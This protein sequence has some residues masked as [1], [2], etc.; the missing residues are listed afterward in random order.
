VPAAALNRRR[1]EAH[2]ARLAAQA[3][4]RRQELAAMKAGA[5]AA[6]ATPPP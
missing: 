5:S 3:E 4:E 1:Y 6:N 2:A